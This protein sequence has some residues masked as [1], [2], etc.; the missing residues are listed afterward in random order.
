VEADMTI[1]GSTVLVSGANRGIGRALVEEALARG[2]QRVYA[3]TRQPLTHPDSRVVP[4][5]LDVTDASSIRATVE[6]IPELDVLVNNAGV[7]TYEDHGDRSSLERHLSVNLFGTYDLTQSLLP[8]LT[9]SRGAVVNVLSVAALASL[10]LMPAYSAS[11]AAALSMS[12]TLRAVLAPRGVVVHVVLA[13]PVDTDMVRDLELPK[14]AAEVVARGILDGVEGGVDDIFPDPMSAAMADGWRH[15]MSK[16][17]EG[18]F[19]ALL[20]PVA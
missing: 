8:A 17:L 10:P 14:T 18:E 1:A 9:A 4:V 3:G 12:Q 20:Q 19:A 5:D 2:A 15:S 7:G 16:R 6:Q 13:G 11:K